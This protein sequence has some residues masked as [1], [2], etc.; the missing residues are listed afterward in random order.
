MFLRFIVTAVIIYL[1]YR[2]A[3][4]LFLTSTRP[5]DK[6]PEGVVSIE[7]EDL[8]MDPY[9]HT[10]VPIS[11]AYRASING[12]T[13]YFCSEECFNKYKAEGKSSGQ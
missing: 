8:V 9:C 6:F 13:V 7:K 3:K 1:V 4:S 12:K 11:D 10:Y 5:P 2:L